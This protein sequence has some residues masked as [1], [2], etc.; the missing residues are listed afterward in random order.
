L[1]DAAKARDIEKDCN[2]ESVWSLGELF[3]KV[4][5]GEAT[6]KVAIGGVRVMTAAT[7]FPSVAIDV[8]VLDEPTA[9]PVEIPTTTTTA[10]PFVVP[11][12][13]G[14]TSSFKALDT[15]VSVDPVPTELAEVPAATLPVDSAPPPTEPST[16]ADA[17][18]LLPSLPTS[19]SR[20]VKGSTGGS[21]ALVALL[22]L[23]G[24][25]LLA[26][27]DRHVM[28]RGNRKIAES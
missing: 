27:A 10:A 16:T 24:V 8:P 11:P 12:A 22:G 4:L 17:S 3:L 20:F 14:G 13:V 19:T 26:A 15:S 28:N 6:V 1:I 2:N 25:L 18:A 21:A 5:H 23:G 9:V 7:V